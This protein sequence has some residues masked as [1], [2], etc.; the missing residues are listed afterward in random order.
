MSEEPDQP[1]PGMNL[2]VPLVPAQPST[3]LQ[4]HRGFFEEPE[5]EVVSLAH[6]LDVLRRRKWLAPDL[7]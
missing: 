2:P 5:E 3:A 4:K 6:Y 7:S 1:R